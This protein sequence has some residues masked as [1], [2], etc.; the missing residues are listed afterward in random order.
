MHGVVPPLESGVV[1]GE[2][3]TEHFEILSQPTEPSLEVQPEGG[4]L[5]DC[6]RPRCPGATGHG[7]VPGV[8][9]GLVA[10]PWAHA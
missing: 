2:Q 4:V 5:G 7:L 10:A 6:S 8:P 9:G 1:I 3:S